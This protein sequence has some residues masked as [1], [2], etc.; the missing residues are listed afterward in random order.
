ML[1]I[2]FLLLGAAA[3]RPFWHVVVALGGLSLALAGLVAA[4][5]MDGRGHLGHTLFGLVFLG[6]ALVHLVPVI[7]ARGR[8][9]CIHRL[10]RLALPLIVALVLLAPP[11]VHADWVASLALAV[12][13]VVE[14]VI[15]MAV[16]LVVHIPRWRRSALVA[17]I[18]LASA[19]ALVAQ[20]P[21]P[22]AANIALVLAVALAQSG[23]VLVRLGW[24][25][26]RWPGE[27]SI[28]RMPL[29]ACRTW[30]DH[31]PNLAGY[32]PPRQADQ[33]PLIMH[34]WTPVGSGN[35]T[36]RLPVV[37]RYF[38]VPD[39]D[40]GVS[41][42]H[43]S[44]DLA[45]DLYVSYYPGEE[46][47][48]SSTDFISTM[49]GEPSHDI[50]GLVVPSF[51]FEVEDWCPANLHMPIHRFSE[52]RLRAFW[53]S[54]RQD[55]T[56]SLVNRNCAAAVAPGLEAAWEG[57]LHCARPWV[58][59]VRLLSDPGLWLAALIRARAEYM[60][61]TPGLAIDYAGE[62]IRVF[63]QVELNWRQVLVPSRARRL[64]PICDEV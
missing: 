27:T 52:R 40:G 60:T 33:P 20:W 10:A 28:L 15:R 47:Q 31:A 24:T 59:L 57:E 18:Q 22:A 30:Q 2:A 19:A 12:A 13:L 34:G 36:M 61:W 58:R 6:L 35:V 23:C 43:V 51:A 16:A 29:Y 37:D 11:A 63:E 5:A 54:F 62:L 64:P 39:A 49:S 25:L 55:S 7:A 44:L 9:E 8:R 42:G 21:L 45:P 38:A 46:I 1:K 32:D 50:K 48:R 26:R 17:A 41:S 56:Y 4:D 3:F 53:D 14:G